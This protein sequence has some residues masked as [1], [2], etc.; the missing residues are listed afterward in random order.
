[1]KRLLLSFLLPLLLVCQA[2][3]QVPKII[4][5]KPGRLIV[6]DSGAKAE[7]VWHVDRNLRDPGSHYKDLAQKRLV[8]VSANPGTFEILALEKGADTF[9]EFL[10]VVDGTPLPVPPGPNPVPVPVPVNT[11]AVKLTF[12]YESDKAQG[13]ATDKDKSKL[14]KVYQ[15]LQQ[16]VDT[17]LIRTVYDASQ[18]RKATITAIVGQA[19][20][21]TI[22]VIDDYL[23]EKI[24]EPAGDESKKIDLTQVYRQRY[25]D[26][27]A[28]I[29]KAL[30]GEPDPGPNPV[31][32]SGFRVIFAYESM[33][34]MSKE[35]LNI[36]GSTKIAAYL[37]SKC[38]K[39]DGHPG[40]RKYDK[41]VVLLA[42]KPKMK[43]VWDANR[44][45]VTTLPS[46]IIV[47][48]SRIDVVPLPATESDTLELLKKY[49]G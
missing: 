38:E 11:L 44:S 31:P 8:V 17:P 1:M 41:D 48:G 22:R 14:T 12:A 30:G 18:V 13:K 19:L 47:N 21:Q 35:Q 36:I 25:K 10:I 43:S 46:L 26:C 3:A 42:E 7:V 34:N 33:A 15:E 29:A 37:N 23:A 28:D 20:P 32:A 49:G 2:D 4:A 45:K 16:Y 6:I 27:F 9:L 39:D 40:W 5:G 24:P